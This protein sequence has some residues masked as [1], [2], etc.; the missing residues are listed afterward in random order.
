MRLTRCAARSSI[1]VTILGRRGPHQIMMTPKEL[2][3]L[4]KLADAAPEVDAADLPELGED[5]LLEP[6]LRK[7]VTLLRDFAARGANTDKPI[8]I[9]FDF[10]ASPLRLRGQ[11]GRVTAIEVER[12]AVDPGAR[13]DGETMCWRRPGRELHRLSAQPIEGVPFESARRFAMREADRARPVLRRMVA[14]RASA[15]SAQ[16]PFG[17][18]V[19]ERMAPSDAGGPS[20]AEGFDASRRVGSTS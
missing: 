14:P 8:T 11:D 13:S 7:S 16:P 20:R 19:I 18:G 9:A 6:G 3:E 4:G 1:G 12:T 15:R 5:A 10:F 17:F 2:G